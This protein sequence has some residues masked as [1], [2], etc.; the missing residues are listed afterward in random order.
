MLLLLQVRRFVS[1]QYA[2]TGLT[3]HPGH[4]PVEVTQ[5]PDGLL[6][7]VTADKDGNKQEIKDNDYVSAWVAHACL[8]ADSNHSRS[9]AIFC[10]ALI[11]GLAVPH[12][13]ARRAPQ[14]I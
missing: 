7:I 2:L 4:V 5:Q 13:V 6:T 3:M 9:M 14:E 1:D 8:Q 12:M 10:M 11:P